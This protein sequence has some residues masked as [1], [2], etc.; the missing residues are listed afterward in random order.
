[1][2][3]I[4]FPDGFEWGA[5]TAA[6][7]IEGGN[8]NNDW[9]QWEHAP[10]SPCVEPSGDAC[11]SWNRWRD[12][13]AVA[14][15]LGF[16]TIDSR[17]SGAASSPSRASGRP[18]RS[19]TTCALGEALLE[20]A[21]SRSSPSTTSRRRDGWRTRADGPTPDTADRF[22]R[23]LSPGC[24]AARTG[25]ARACTI[26]EPNI[27][28]GM[29][30][31]MGMFPPGDDRRSAARRRSPAS[32]SSRTAWPSRP[33]GPGRRGCPSGSRCRWPTTSRRD[34]EARRITQPRS[35]GGRVPRRD[36]G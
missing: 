13:V 22:A 14:A 18:R 17:S 20:P 11:D 19:T 10:D 6:H 1:M 3:R 26:N 29:A 2:T 27:V 31:Q 28:A 5:A 36:R 34:G 7:Q 16:T 12:D 33:S 8:W 15:E 4:Q 23:F 35:H 30:H 24:R 21:S 32:S 25:P 9:W